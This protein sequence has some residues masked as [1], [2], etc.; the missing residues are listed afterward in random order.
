MINCRFGSHTRVIIL[1]LCINRE[2]FSMTIRY[3]VFDWIKAEALLART[4]HV[5]IQK[6]IS[7][8]NPPI[9]LG[10]VLS[11]SIPASRIGSGRD[12][13]LKSVFEG[14][15]TRVEWFHFQNG[16][17]LADCSACFIK[18][19]GGFPAWTPKCEEAP[20]Q[21]IGTTP[22]CCVSWP[23]LS[24]PVPLCLCSS[25][26]ANVTRLYCSSFLNCIPIFLILGGD[27]H[28][29][30]SQHGV[31]SEKEMR[32]YAT[33]IILGLEHMHNRFVVYRDLKVITVTIE[34]VCTQL[35]I[36]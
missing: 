3:R 27:L 20:L 28:Y 18:V 9:S 4:L 17:T 35:V 15:Q 36:R 32:F 7:V 21:V 26:P 23:S 29:H 19:L 11:E 8:R 6:Y 2:Q 12:A 30:L 24:C 22:S 14:E 16:V 33:E 10:N 34:T 5:Q 13:S 25:L 1:N 31:F